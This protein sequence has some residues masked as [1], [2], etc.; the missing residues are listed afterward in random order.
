MINFRYLDSAY[1]ELS[2][3]ASFTPKLSSLEGKTWSQRQH[4]EKRAVPIY[5][6]YRYTTYSTQ[7]LLA[8][9]G[10]P[11]NADLGMEKKVFL[12]T[13]GTKIK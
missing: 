12:F 9:A 1:I 4:R 7:H 10:F 11:T 5:E 8:H 13:L 2:S 3:D 6:V